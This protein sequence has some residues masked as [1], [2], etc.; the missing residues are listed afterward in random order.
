MKKR[1]LTARLGGIPTVKDKKRFINDLIRSVKKSIL[2]K[3]KEMPDEWDGIEL[4]QFIVDYFEA[5][6]LM[7]RLLYGH[8][9]ANYNNK[10]RVKNL[11]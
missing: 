4:R 9:R 3:V 5:H 1:I 11:L 7:R 2:V 8:R 10:L 6:T